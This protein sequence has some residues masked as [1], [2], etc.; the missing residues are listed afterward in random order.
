[1]K[2]LYCYK[3][4]PL[5]SSGRTR[6]FVALYGSK[7]RRLLFLTVGSLHDILYSFT[8]VVFYVT[9]VTKTSLMSWCMQIELIERLREDVLGPEKNVARPPKSSC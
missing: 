2:Y 9:L 6:L 5:A 4:F 7:K 3:L 1:M 8:F